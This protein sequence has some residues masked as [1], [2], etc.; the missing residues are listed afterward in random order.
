[1]DDVQLAAGKRMGPFFVAA[2]ALALCLI[3]ATFYTM[4]SRDN[5]RMAIV[6][7]LGGA[8]WPFQGFSGEQLFVVRHPDGFFGLIPAGDP[9]FTQFLVWSGVVGLIISAIFYWRHPRGFMAPVLLVC[10]MV[11]QGIALA[12]TL[13]AGPDFVGSPFETIIDPATRTVTGFGGTVGLCTITGGLV[14]PATRSLDVDLTTP[15]G[16]FTLNSFRDPDAAQA[17]L[18]EVATA[19]R[20]SCGRSEVRE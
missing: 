11:P 7:R 19:I 13:S 8:L 15:A 18:E 12:A 6:D 16:N 14:A 9:G 1:M 4:T 20:I 2:W 3:C 10:F 5:R 17:L